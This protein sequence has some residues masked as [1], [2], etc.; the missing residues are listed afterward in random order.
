MIFQTRLKTLFLL[1]F[2]FIVGQSVEARHIIGSDFY[3]DCQGPGRVS[4]SKTYS[5]HLDVYRDCSTNILFNTNAS[6]GIYKFSNSTGYTFVD[7]F[8]IG[9]GTI[10]NVRP[11]Q[12]PC[13]I[14]PPNV[15]VET[16]DYQFRIDLP[17]ISETYVIFY[18]QCCRNRTILNIP[19]PGVTGATFFIEISPQSQ[20][21]CNNSPRFKV[22]PPIVICADFALNFDH[23]A[24]DKEG[25]S[26]VYEFCP[27]LSGGGG[28]GGFGIPG[29]GPG[30]CNSPTPDPRIC[31]PPFN[32]LGSVPGYTYQDPM[33][34]G[35][36]TLDRITGRLTGR[37][38]NL[39]Q[40]VVGVCV[41]EYRNGVLIGSIHRDFQF[42]IAICEQTVHAKVKA[43]SGSDK[44]FTINFCGDN[45]VQFTNESFTEEYIK[46]YYWEFKAKGSSSPVEL[47]TSTDK[48]AK[49][50]F[51]R[52][53]QYSGM[54]IVN[55]NALVCN[56]TAFIDLNIIPSDIKSD[57]SFEYDKC[58]TLPIKF[59]DKSTGVLTPV[60]TY[61]WTFGDGKSANIR[62]PTHLF[63][64]P[65]KYN[66]NLQVTD[67]KLCKSNKTKELSYFPAP[68]L[69]DILPDKFRAC[70]PGTIHFKNLS[71]P[72]DSTYLVEWDF[73]DG[74]KYTGVDAKHTYNK[75]G[76]YTIGLSLKA[77]SGCITRE[78]FPN[79]V[80]VQSGPLADFN[81]TPEKPTNLNS[82]VQFVNLSRDGIEYSWDF[83][84]ESGGI[85]KNPI[86]RYQDTGDYVV[87]LVVRHE[88]GCRDSAIRVVRVGLH[89]TYFLPN[90]FTP[91]N[92]GI[93]DIYIGAGS[94]AGMQSFDLSI[95]NRW[96]ELIYN[97]SDPNLGWNG[98]KQNKG[99]IEPNGV[100]ICV[101]KYKNDRG[102]PKELKGFATL[103]R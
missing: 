24:S 99:N 1:S 15:C 90:A 55:R 72:V 47:I 83:G 9:H 3:Y 61:E 64:Q 26:L 103:I 25:D 48:N 19:N 92:D 76:S 70:V 17:I 32:N 79:F 31:P 78:T 85:E 81:F 67:G 33:G 51:T 95:F 5:F 11:D 38:T 12:N 22:F 40:Y 4:N 52:P 14:I 2:A 73:G 23:S 100:Y 69:L 94:F 43:D 60:K 34:V 62:S 98:K 49:L 39:G 30:G 58:S 59:T 63:Q 97:T 8:N 71:I 93:N 28:G 6:F 10:S 35:V 57:F 77:P 16:T 96:G 80:R 91:N 37:P 89:I 50:T 42:N 74:T 87:N 53:G 101:V 84:D 29:T 20:Q 75:A 13:I 41:K 66:I 56:D 82:T 54:M 18:I 45:E 65:G 36:L 44:R 7:Q 27:L 86:H 46:N 68:A 21:T 88:N 102:D